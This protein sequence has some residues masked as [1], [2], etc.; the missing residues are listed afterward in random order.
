M[1]RNPIHI[2]V[3]GHTA[4]E[5]SAI[6]EGLTRTNLIAEVQRTYARML[7]A[8]RQAEFA[9]VQT[10]SNAYPYSN[11]HSE[12]SN[13]REVL[14]P[15]VTRDCIRCVYHVTG[16]RCFGPFESVIHVDVGGRKRAPPI[17]RSRSTPI[18]TS[19]WRVLWRGICPSSSLAK[20]SPNSYPVA[21]AQAVW[22]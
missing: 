1:D 6:A 11:R 21:A 17:M 8:G 2:C 5:F 20:G 15:H 10:S 19:P 3:T 22:T 16:R 9:V 12:H 13:I 18:L 7:P 14:R 4:V